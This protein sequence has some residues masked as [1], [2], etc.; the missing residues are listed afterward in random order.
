MKFCYY[1]DKRILKAGSKTLKK[2][3]ERLPPHLRTIDF[4]ENKYYNNMT[5][6]QLREE[7]ARE[8]NSSY[9]LFVH[10]LKNFI[11]YDLKL[12]KTE[13]DADFWKLVGNPMYRMHERSI[14]ET[15]R[16]SKRY[17]EKLFEQIDFIIDLLKHRKHLKK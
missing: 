6:E 12:D 3:N 9:G 8:L 13:S 15:C 5:D 14:V 2:T 16:K 1:V 11:Q 7:I 4:D 10:E 17:K